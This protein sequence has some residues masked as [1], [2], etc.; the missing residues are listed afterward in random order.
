MLALSLVVVA[1]PIFGFALTPSL[2]PPVLDPA[3][4]LALL[5][6]QDHDGGGRARRRATT[7]APEE[8]ARAPNGLAAFAAQLRQREELAGVHRVLGIATWGAM[9]TTV[10]LGFIHTT[11]STASSVVSKTRR[12]CGARRCSGKTSAGGIHG[13]TASRR[14]VRRSSTRRRS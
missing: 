8:P 4:V 7:R 9:L 6:Q 12:A 13:R 2:T 10:V 5:E 3:P 14:S 11:T 1:T